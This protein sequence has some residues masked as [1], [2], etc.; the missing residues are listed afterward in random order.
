MYTPPQEEGSA[1][2]LQKVQKMMSHYY[3]TFII[4]CCLSFLH[5]LYIDTPQEFF[6]A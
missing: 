4:A 1:K 5:S 6:S 2:L 3:Q